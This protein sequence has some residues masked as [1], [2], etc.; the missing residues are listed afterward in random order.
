MALG[1][2]LFHDPRLSGDNSISCASCHLLNKG[3]VDNLATSTGVDGQKGGINAPTVFNAVFNV[4]QFW[5]GR[6]VDLQQQ[7]GGPPLNPVE[8]ASTSWEDIIAKLQQDPQ[9]TQDFAQVYPQGYSEDT[10]TDAIAEF[11]KTLTTPNS[12]FDHYLKGETQALTT[13]QQK[14]LALFQQNKC[15]TCHVGKNIGGQSYEFLGLKS[16]YFADRQ[17]EQTTDDL[18]R[19]N[20]TNDPR[21]MHRFKTPSLRNIALTAPYFH[22]AQAKDLHQA[23]ELMLKYQVGTQL[24]EQD[25][26]DIVAFLESLTG[27]YIPHS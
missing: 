13:S 16:D 24:P 22:D 18:G 14:G 10:I 15:D 2:R 1:S 3:G 9:L 19:F 11:E 20:V 17:K 12:P 6:A 8:M 5:D 7:A 4:E 25:I 27:E 23:V 26:N 21:D